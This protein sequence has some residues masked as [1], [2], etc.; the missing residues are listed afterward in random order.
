MRKFIAS[1]VL[2]V[3]TFLGMVSIAGACGF[4]WYQAELP[5]KPENSNQ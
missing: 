1:L 2:L 5:Q 4:F 3:V